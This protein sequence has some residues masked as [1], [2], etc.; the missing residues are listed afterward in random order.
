MLLVGLTGGIGSGK[1]TAR[2]LLGE[3]RGVHCLDLDEVY[4][5]LVCV[6]GPLLPALRREF[7]DKVFREADGALDREAL[8]ALVFADEAARKVF[9]IGWMGFGWC[10]AVAMN[11]RSGFAETEPPDAPRHL[12]EP[13][14]EA[15]VALAQGLSHCGH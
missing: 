10:D 11:M 6:G 5:E 4:S 15:G 13:P 7:G 8:G 14:E 3:Q 12:P 9:R 2:R 1:S